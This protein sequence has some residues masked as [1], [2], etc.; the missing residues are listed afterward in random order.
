MR[1]LCSIIV[2]L[3]HRERQ[4]HHVW[5]VRYLRIKSRQPDHLVW[6]T[7]L[8]NLGDPDIHAHSHSVK[9]D[10]G[11]ELIVE[12]AIQKE[13]LHRSRMEGRQPRSQLDRARRLLRLREVDPPSPRDFRRLLLRTLL[14]KQAYVDGV[15]GFPFKKY[16]RSGV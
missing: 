11:V 12:E 6:Q 16:R 3:W 2:E 7:L 14:S 13:F 15:G 9:G 8:H 5:V 4:T 10:V 1:R